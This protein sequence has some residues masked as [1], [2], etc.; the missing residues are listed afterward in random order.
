M[1]C[2]S[3]RTIS[4][5]VP[6]LPVPGRERPPVAT[7]TAA[8]AIVSPPA[9]RTVQGWPSRGGERASAR[10]SKRISAP[11]RRARAIS[12]SR[13]SRELFE[14]GNSLPVSGSRASG[15]PT[16][17]SKNRRCS[18]SGQELRILRSV[19]GEEP[20]TKRAGSTAEGR[21]LHRPPPLTRIFRPPSRVRSRSR[22]RRRFSGGP[23]AKT[24]ARSPAAPAPRMTVGRGGGGIGRS[25]SAEAAKRDS[26]DNRDFRDKIKKGFQSPYSP[27]CPCCP[28]CPFFPTPP[29]SPARST[30]GMPG[31]RPAGLLPA[32]PA[33]GGGEGG[34]P[35]EGRGYANPCTPGLRLL[36]EAPGSLAGARP[37]VPAR[38]S[39]PDLGVAPDLVPPLRQGQASLH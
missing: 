10:A 36:R 33:R 16:S 12:L 26:R 39:V 20:V 35:T 38:H 11:R 29:P 5:P 13:T 3:R 14:T 19:L 28:C 8:A 23:A 15:M 17:S 30:P 21:T 4:K 22:T 31:R 6:S 7:I 34:P 37:D 9:R 24:A 1:V 32:T 25:V 18:G 2:P 27:C